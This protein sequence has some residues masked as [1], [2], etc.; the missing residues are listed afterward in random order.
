M[1]KK[2]DKRP[3]QAAQQLK[4][5]DRPPFMSKRM[6]LAL[7]IFLV[8]VGVGFMRW[9]QYQRVHIN[10]QL[11]SDL[12]NASY[13]DFNEVRFFGICKFFV[14]F[15]IRKMEYKAMQNRYFIINVSSCIFARHKAEMADFSLINY[16]FIQLPIFISEK[17]K[18]KFY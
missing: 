9:L 15:G 13:S 6:D 16:A 18:I 17:C 2:H 4:L 10:P 11:K 1:A 5:G 3:P 7:K 14:C 8:V 12:A